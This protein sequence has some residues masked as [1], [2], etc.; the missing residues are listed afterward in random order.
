LK[1][2]FSLQEAEKDKDKLERVFDAD[3]GEGG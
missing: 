3:T 2:S 1:N